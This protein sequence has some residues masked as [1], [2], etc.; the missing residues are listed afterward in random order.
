[1]TAL[2]VVA[3]ASNSESCGGVKEGVV[4]HGFLQGGPPYQL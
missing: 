2:S 3:A 1:M 4:D